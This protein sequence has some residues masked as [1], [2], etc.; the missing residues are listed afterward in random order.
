M[1]C[2][3]L[4]HRSG[5]LSV[6]AALLALTT[7]CGGPGV[8]LGQVYGTVTM[9]GKPVPRAQLTFTPD[10]PG[11]GATGLANEKGEYVMEYTPDAAGA[12]VG[13]VTVQIR[14]KTIDTPEMIPPKYNEKTELK[15]EVK[16]GS[17]EINFELQSGGWKAK[18][19]TDSAL[20]KPQ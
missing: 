15:R 8:K 5:L 19:G 7:G 6:S 3:R 10:G 14:T 20:A 2:A 12:L 1:P 4:F 13:P 9:D 11:R 18:P 17:N 16:S